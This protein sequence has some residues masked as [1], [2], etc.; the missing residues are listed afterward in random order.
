MS[1]ETEAPPDSGREIAD[2][3]LDEISGWYR[4]GRVPSVSLDASR[5]RDGLTGPHGI[6]VAHAYMDY[7][8]HHC[9]LHIDAERDI[10]S[11]L[12]SLSS[13]FR[14]YFEEAV[15]DQE[16][17]E[18]VVDIEYCGGVTLDTLRGFI[19]SHPDMLLR[20]RFLLLYL[21]C[22]ALGDNNSRHPDVDTSYAE[23]VPFET[24]RSATLSKA[25]SSAKDDTIDEQI[26]CAFKN[27]ATSILKEHVDRPA[28]DNLV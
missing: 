21:L 13:V 12:C 15:T 2:V 1:S 19:L 10:C 11:P 9:R 4:V 24:R 22:F 17:E 16:G 25:F 7:L 28:Q 14:P 20:K 6:E 27:A 3:I 5:M 23:S 8:I 26:L 18:A